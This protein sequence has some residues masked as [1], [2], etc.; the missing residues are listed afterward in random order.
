MTQNEKVIIIDENDNFQTKEKALINRKIDTLYSVYVF[1]FNSQNKL[2]LSVVPDNHL[3]TGKMSVTIATMVRENENNDMA[4]TRVL[5][6]ELF[7]ENK[8]PVFLGEERAAFP[9]GIKRL[10]A[11]YYFN[12]EAETPEYN[13][14]D[15]VEMRMAT[16]EEVEKLLENPENF[17]ETF[18]WAWEKYHNKLPF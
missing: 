10:M 16:R 3:Y 14:K 4:A 11:V 5:K 1:V 18:L 2:I 13:P 12:H 15:I 7:L 8:N 17:S 9:D 6:K